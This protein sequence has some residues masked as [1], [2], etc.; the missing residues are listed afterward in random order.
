MDDELFAVK[1]KIK[2]PFWEKM[3]FILFFYNSLIQ[4]EEVQRH[5]KLPFYNITRLVS[6][7]FEELI[8]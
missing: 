2:A 7:E 4:T 1:K 8:K 5:I 6:T 3:F